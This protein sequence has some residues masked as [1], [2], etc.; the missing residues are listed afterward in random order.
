MLFI[1]LYYYPTNLFC[2]RALCHPILIFAWH[3][4]D[5]YFSMNTEK[6]AGHYIFLLGFD[7]NTDEVRFLDPSSDSAVKYVSSAILESA[8]SQPGTD[9]DII[10]VKR[11]APSKWRYCLNLN[12]LWLIQRFNHLKV[13][14]TLFWPAYQTK[15]LPSTRHIDIA[16]RSRLWVSKAFKITSSGSHTGHDAVTAEEVRGRYSL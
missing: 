12:R 6:Y 8:R 5:S 15:A 4:F 11:V 16:S 1:E 10:L 14:V 2:I 3:P 7:P 9:K 13:K